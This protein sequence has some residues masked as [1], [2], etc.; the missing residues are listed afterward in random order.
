VAEVQDL[1]A[2]GIELIREALGDTT[3]TLIQRASTHAFAGVITARRKAPSGGDAER[4]E[5][6]LLIPAEAIDATP[7]ADDRV[8]LAGFTGDAWVVAVANP[9]AAGGSPIAW[10]LVLR[11]WVA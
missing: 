6:A 8:T 2:E 5:I 11:N 10:S 9:I 1:T 3:G 7:E 4:E